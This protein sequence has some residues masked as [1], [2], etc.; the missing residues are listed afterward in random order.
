VSEVTQ[1]NGGAPARR[2]EAEMPTK[3]DFQNLVDWCALPPPA[4][5]LRRTIGAELVS[6]PETGHSAWQGTLTYIAPNWSRW[7]PEHF[8]GRLRGVAGSTLPDISL[9]FA[10]GETWAV[11]DVISPA[12]TFE[13]YN[14][15][16]VQDFGGGVLRVWIDSND[17]RM[18]ECFLWQALAAI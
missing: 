1:F 8:Q 15:Q 14:I 6:K 10:V 17:A 16:D 12:G 13:E 4:D 3:A 18:L 2:E 11:A 5:Y 7:A 9:E